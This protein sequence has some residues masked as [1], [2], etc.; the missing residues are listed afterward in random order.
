MSAPAP[1]DPPSGTEEAPN[2]NSNPMTPKGEKILN[3]ERAFA[4]IFEELMVW[5]VALIFSCVVWWWY[6]FIPFR[7]LTGRHEL[8]GWSEGC[9]AAM[10]RREEDDSSSTTKL[11][12]TTISRHF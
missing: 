10:A 9:C 8:Q 7:S 12:T 2:F 3:N 4:L 5:Q 6:I 1:K 11:V